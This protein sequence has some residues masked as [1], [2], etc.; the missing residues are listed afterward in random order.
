MFFRWSW[1]TV[2][3]VDSQGVATPR[4]RTVALEQALLECHGPNPGRHSSM[5]QLFTV[6]M[7]PI[8]ELVNDT[9]GH[10][11]TH[12]VTLSCPTLLPVVVASSGL[13]I[14]LRLLFVLSSAALSP[15]PNNLLNFPAPPLWHSHL[16]LLLQLYLPHSVV[17]LFASVCSLPDPYPCFT[18][19]ALEDSSFSDCVRPTSRL[20]LTFL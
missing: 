11:A 4:L 20:P 5:Q 18:Q 10:M 2:E 15:A 14:L 12:S 17:T 1:V 6:R 13:C 9:W 19:K 8:R 16:H 7:E 3:K